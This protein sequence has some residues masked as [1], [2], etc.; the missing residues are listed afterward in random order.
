MQQRKQILTPQIIKKTVEEV[1]AGK[2]SLASIRGI[3]KETM[4]ACYAAGYNF[5]NRGRFIDALNIFTTLCMFDNINAKYWLGLGMTRQVL[6][7]FSGAVEA[8]GVA[9]MLD[10]TNPKAPFHAADCLIALKD[11]NMAKLALEAVISTIEKSK[12][13]KK[14]HKA[15]LAQAKNLL[16]LIKKGEKESKEPKAQVKAEA[17]KVAAN[18]VSVGPKK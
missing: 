13:D 10:Q 3:P 1:L 8:Y 2:K 4:D 14:E 9:T 7:D 11:Y 15:M 18:K 5:Y 17:N 16:E 6:K 12:S